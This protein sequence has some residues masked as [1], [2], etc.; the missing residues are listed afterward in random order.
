MTIVTCQWDSMWL[1]QSH[2][3]HVTA[4]INNVKAT[5]T[6]INVIQITDA[7]VTVTRCVTIDTITVIKAYRLL[8]SVKCDI[9]QSDR[10]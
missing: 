7:L 4:A 5:V 8:L 2:H 3:Y 10:M 6:N 1:F 9:S